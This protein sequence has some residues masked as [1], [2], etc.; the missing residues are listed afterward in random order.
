MFYGWSDNRTCQDCGGTL[1]P[2][3]E[4]MQSE[5]FELPTYLSM[6]K[7][8]PWQAIKEIITCALILA[9][10]FASFWTKDILLWIEGVMP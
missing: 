9:A 8:T 7:H 3:E 5:P 1:K 4:M 2:K 6:I 10:M